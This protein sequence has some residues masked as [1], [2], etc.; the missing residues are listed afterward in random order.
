MTIYFYSTRDQYGEFSNFSA[1]G[2][3]IDGK[4]YPTTEHYFQAQKYV[5]TKPE[6]AERICQAKTP[7]EAAEL[8]RNRAVPIRS[9]WEKVKD[10]IM[11]EAVTAKFTQHSE[12][13][14][15]LL[16]T[17]VAELV[18]NTSGDYYW[19]CGTKGTGKN[20]LGKIL[21]QVRS[22]LQILPTQ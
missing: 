6:Y 1:H 10:N 2:V 5:E 22:E 15:L 21:V 17:G 4:Y 12:L 9:D 7:K 18:E 19:G 3:T 11:L 16:S 8:G 13:K 14:K 20:M